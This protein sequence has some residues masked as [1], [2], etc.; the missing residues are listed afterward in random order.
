[1]YY[2]LNKSIEKLN[3]WFQRP[4][5]GDSSHNNEDV[6]FI[7]LEFLIVYMIKELVFKE[8]KRNFLI[9]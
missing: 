4:D 9:E 3:T 1:M 6:V 8:K 2:Y 7:K 5:Y